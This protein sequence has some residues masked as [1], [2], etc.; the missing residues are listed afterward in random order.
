MKGLLWHGR[1][2]AVLSELTGLSRPETQRFRDYLQE[3]YYRIPDYAHYAR[4]GIAIGSGSVESQIEQIAARV[5]LTGAIG[6]RE[7][8]PQILRLRCAYLNDDPCLHD[9]EG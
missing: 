4:L 8:V 2:D 6:H 1:V 9:L 7:N 3:H 5:K